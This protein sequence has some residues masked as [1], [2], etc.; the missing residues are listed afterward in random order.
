[1]P[2]CRFGHAL[3]TKEKK[4]KTVK[5]KVMAMIGSVLLAGAVF[6]GCGGKTSASGISGTGASSEAASS[7]V[8]SAVS[9]RAA[10]EEEKTV[11]QSAAEPEMV[12]A[13]FAST[14]ESGN[15]V[16]AASSSQEAGTTLE[17]G[18]YMAKFDTDSSMFR[19]NDMDYGRGVLTVKNGKMSIHIRLVSQNIVN[20]FYGNKEDAQ[21]EGAELI[22]P[23]VETVDYGDGTTEDVNCFDVPVP[24]LDQEFTV[25]LIGTHG[26]WYEHQVTVSDPVPAVQ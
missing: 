17:D 24:A 12:S 21:K 22:D 14:S 6:A 3:A 1:M 5:K 11:S 8:E 7:S 25:S 18:I 4:E 10:S 9:V 2:A 16:S 23:T 15:A 13:A 20:L 19:V 26:N